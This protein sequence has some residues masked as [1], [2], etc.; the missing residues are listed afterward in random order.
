[1][2]NLK[3]TIGT[4]FPSV[5]VGAPGIAFCPLLCQQLLK[6]ILHLEDTQ[7]IFLRTGYK[8]PFLV[9]G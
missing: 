7:C 3:K 9:L 2:N 6:H 4:H 8:V 5:T 1:M